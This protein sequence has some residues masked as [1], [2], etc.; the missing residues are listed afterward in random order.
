MATPRRF[1]GQSPLADVA[2]V[3]AEGE[4]NQIIPSVDGA[5]ERMTKTEVKDELWLDSEQIRDYGLGD[6]VLSCQ[7][8][9]DTVPGD[10][11]VIAIRDPNHP[12]HR[13]RT[14]RVRQMQQR[15]GDVMVAK[16]PTGAPSDIP[17]YEDLI[18]CSVPR[19]RW[20][21]IHVRQ[22]DAAMKEFTNS[23]IAGKIE[24]REG[25]IEEFKQDPEALMRA[26]EETHNRLRS[27]GIVEKRPAN[28]GYSDVLHF[29][30]AE[31]TKRIERA[32]ARGGRTEQP[33]EYEEYEREQAK[34][35][36]KNRTYSTP[37]RP[38]R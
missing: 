27:T 38:T 36:G 19:D 29:T 12:M 34:S 13:G 18:Y 25:L 6:A 26:K 8:A 10:R 1:A 15:Y 4:E 23:V 28:M 31:E 24:G 7:A 20:L 32:M 16:A 37:G 9:D 2:A 5:R 17:G 3:T 30:G 11:V 33:G 14:S 35:R 22:H 21:D